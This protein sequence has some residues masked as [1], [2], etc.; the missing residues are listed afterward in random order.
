[1]R[2]RKSGKSEQQARAPVV[3]IVMGSESDL[4]IIREA[5]KT[6]EELRIPCEVHIISAHRT[7][8]R[9][10][11]FAEKAAG[12][13]IKVII[14]GAGGAAHLAGAIAARTVLPVIGVPIKTQDMAGL[15]S[16]LSTLQMPKGVPVATVA[17]D[18][19]RNAALLAAEI[20][21]LGDAALT[22]EL[23]NMRR[24][25]ETEIEEKSGQLG[26]MEE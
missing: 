17:I 26:L 4:P 25:M 5:A 12:R 19:A 8:R 10:A 2:S 15:D 6:L 21:A 11:E 20:L 18:G 13:G 1:M 16:L 24:R 14:A 3:A 23:Q 9:A 22:D 7:P